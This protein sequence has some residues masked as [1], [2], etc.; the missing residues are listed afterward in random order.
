MIEGSYIAKA[1]ARPTDFTITTHLDERQVKAQLEQSNVKVDLPG[2]GGKTQIIN[3]ISTIII[4]GLIGALVWHQM[5]IGKAK[6]S[7]KIKGRPS[8]RFKD[9]AGVEEAKAEVQEIVDFLRN[10]KKYKRQGGNLPKGVL[11]I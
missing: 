10:P 6:S 2:Q 3:I 9:V 8:T 4:V 11:L 7:H 1:G 5:R